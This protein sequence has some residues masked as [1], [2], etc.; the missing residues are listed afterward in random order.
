M[1]TILI[2]SVIA[3]IILK[4]SKAIKH[5]TPIDDPNMEL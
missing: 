5:A 2:I 3:Y 1:V 4:I